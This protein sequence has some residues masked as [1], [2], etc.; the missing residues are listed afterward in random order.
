MKAENKPA[1]RK[2]YPL[3]MLRAAG[4]GLLLWFV[5]N[6]IDWRA[7]MQALQ[8]SRPEYLLLLPLVYFLNNTISA[9]RWTAILSQWNIQPGFWNLWKIYLISSF[10]GNF[11]PST[12]GGDGYR[13]LA[14]RPY[15]NVTNTKILASI[16]LDRLYGLIALIL[17]HY[18]ILAFYWRNLQ[19]VPLLFRTELI[20]TAGFVVFGIAGAA[21]ALY[22][23]KTAKIPV[24][25][26]EILKR[27]TGKLSEAFRLL[28]EQGWRNAALGIFY[29][30]LFVSIIA[31][32]WQ[33]F[34]FTVDVPITLGVGFYSATLV[35]I[36]GLLPI[37]VNGIGILEAALAA[38]FHWQ[39]V[40]IEKAL[41]AVI[42]IR[43]TQVLLT[44]PGGLLYMLDK[45]SPNVKDME[46]KTQ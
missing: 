32:T 19:S 35:G 16:F 2:K 3:Q 26:H 29:S 37:T 17:M 40:P 23:F 28:Q 34:Y 43:I 11:L 22:I 33:I 24:F 39:A 10:W 41:L 15:P 27:I 5:L 45:S 9:L 6:G 36:L 25:K 44:L 30:A 12:I 13:F 4:S 21:A 18:V 38:I 14:L 42:L 7:F 46:N 1:S 31:A 8:Q 20:M